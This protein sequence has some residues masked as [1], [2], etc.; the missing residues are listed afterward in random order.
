MRNVDLIKSKAAQNQ[1]HYIPDAKRLNEYEIV[2]V[3]A[4]MSQKKNVEYEIDGDELIE[5]SFAKGFFTR[6]VIL[7]VKE[8]KVTLSS[9]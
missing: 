3:I 7:N 2:G 4:K 6:W 5:Y 8:N 9:I 1:V